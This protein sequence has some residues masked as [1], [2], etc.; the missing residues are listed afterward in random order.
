MA[1]T[2]R[3]IAREAGFSVS[4]VVSVLGNRGKFRDR[5]RDQVLSTAER[6]GYRPN[7]VA[8]AIATGRFGCV[9]LVL[10]MEQQYS[11]L[12]FQLLASIHDE[13]AERDLHLV[14][15]RLP[16]EKLTS[17]QVM[18]KLLREWLADAVLINYTDHIPAGLQ[19]V[20][21]EHEI[22]AIWL[23]TRRDKNCVHPDD[24]GAAR[25]LTQA[26]IAQGHRRI[27]YVDYSHAVEELAEKH[28]SARDRA[29]GYRTAMQA[30][31]LE[32]DVV[33][34]PSTTEFDVLDRTRASLTR[35]LRPTAVVA[36]GDEI[37]FV[38]VAALSIGLRV[39]ENLSVATFGDRSVNFAGTKITT[40]IV[41]H[42]AM[43]RA[44]VEA[45][46]WKLENG[47]Q[48]VPAVSIPFEAMQGNS[49]LPQGKATP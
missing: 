4:T 38:C 46:L 48:P 6:L 22:P 28:Y 27:L 18:P 35:S 32:P 5:T 17:E 40:A 8:K 16:D 15:A 43:A 47:G 37:S 2:V 11:G 14:L 20:V 9:A 44:A 10:G 19:A 1:V 3:D 29:E 24:F 33:W 45:L 23:N 12:P 36:Y 21:E 39:P 25:D 41:P 13:L 49:V 7:A 26:M 31:G 42:R 34:R 30:A